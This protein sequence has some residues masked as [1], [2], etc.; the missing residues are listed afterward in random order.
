[1]SDK[2]QPAEQREDVPEYFKN[3]GPRWP[4]TVQPSIPGFAT[5]EWDIVEGTVWYSEEWKNITQSDY[6]PTKPNDQAWWTE[7]VFPAD[8]AKI[9]KA[10]LAV[11]A[12][13][14]E[15]TE[16]VYRLKREDGVWRT[17]FSRSKVTA[18]TKEGA[19]ALACGICVD[20]TDMLAN[21]LLPMEDSVSDIDFQSMLDNSPDLFIRFNRSLKPVYVNPAVNRYLGGTNNTP[22]NEFRMT[23]DYKEVFQRNVEK[24]FTEKAVVREELCIAMS[25]GSEVI[26]DCS[27]WPEFD[28]EGTVQHAMMQFRDITE[29][30]CMEQRI[31]LNERRLDALYRLTLMDNAQEAEML[32]FVMN[33]LLQLSD[34]SSGFIFFP[35]GEDSDR[36]ILLWSGD[37]YDNFAH[38]YLPDDHLP[39]DLIV[40]MTGT[41]GRR[42]YRS[43]NNAR[44]DTPLHVIFDGKM[45]VERGIISQVMEEGRLVCIAGVCNKDTDYEESDLQQLETFIN[46]AWLILRRRRFLQELQE[47][48]DAAETANKAKNAFL[49]NVSH[50]LRT[51]LNGVLS[52]LQLIDSLP[53][54][55]EQKEYLQTAQASGKALLRIISDLLDYSGMEAGK[56]PLAVDVFDCGAAVRSA[57]GMFA[58]DAARKG[59]KFSYSI[60]PAIPPYL[61]GDEARVRQIVFNVVGNAL[62]FTS[63]G[64]IDVN[65]SLVAGKEPGSAGIEFTVTDTGIG[66]PKDKLASIF[67][68]FNQVEN[69]HRR[70]YKGT[71]LGLSIVKHLVALMQ[72][73]VTVE[74]EIG[75]GTTVR[76]LLYFGLSQE[77]VKTTPAVFPSV[78]EVSGKVLDILVA[79]DDTVGRMA[80]RAFLQKRGHRVLCVQDG[81]LA[82]EALQV[83]PFHCVFT[84]I[85]MPNLDGIGLLRRIR[86]GDTGG[87][88][89]SDA[90]R[91]QVA[92]LF[93]TETD[94]MAKIAPGFTVIAIS[95]HAMMGDK[96]YFLG[97]GMDYYLSKP[98]DGKELDDALDFVIRKVRASESAKD[99]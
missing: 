97:L 32:Q 6:D 90:I 31:K 23:G 25:D 44:G 56:M 96:D 8:M 21:G 61:L 15:T 40:Q 54:G 48:K 68:A 14:L 93:G 35:S 26:G 49:A 87:M 20:I 36:G 95:A 98:I 99:Q 39:H 3:A 33:S 22:G 29:Q 19:P 10:C 91:S 41:D 65:C 60:D 69:S 76:C 53:L 82:M 45:S 80:I 17:L 72:G 34:S 73:S 75:K 11:H 47:A 63:Q 2:R 70:Q 94:A 81:A 86:T 64:S 62:K 27:F 79:E 5:H 12:G 66:I 89:P 42:R 38:H 84:D 71:G 1:M 51:P 13:F 24:V 57:L 46:S 30:R 43:I 52:M 67:E 7:R 83:Y 4:F 78:S 74:S 59:L 77:P 50:E 9:Y 92:E 18:R 37:H 85:T 58:E 28:S 55:N 16:I 88:T